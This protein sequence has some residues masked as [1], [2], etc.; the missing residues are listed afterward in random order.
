MGLLRIQECQIKGWNEQGHKSE[1]KVLKTIC[2]MD[3]ND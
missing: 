3:L 1:C 2:N